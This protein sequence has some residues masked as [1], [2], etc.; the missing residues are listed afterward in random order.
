MTD[1]KREDK[2]TIGV[3]PKNDPSL[4][5]LVEVGNFSQELD[6]ARFAMAYAMKRGVGLG[7]IDGAQTKWNIGTWDPDGGMRSLLEALYPEADGAYRAMEYLLNRGLEMLASDATAH[8]DVAGLIA[9][10]QERA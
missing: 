2:R 6:A 1:E 10:R 9:E 4:T 8:V 3:V 5:R 7:S